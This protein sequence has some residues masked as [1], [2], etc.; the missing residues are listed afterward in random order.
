M[1]RR[2]LRIQLS[3]QDHAELKSLLRGGVQQVRVV[4]R[5]LA[6]LQMADGLTA[7]QVARSVCLTAK[8]VREIAHRY[9]SGGLEQALFEK[10][11]PGAAELLEPPQKQRIVAMV[12][13]SPP[14]GQARWTVRLITE[15]A[16]KRKLVPRVGRETIR[17]LLQSHDLKP[18]R[19]KNV[20]RGGTR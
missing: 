19:E 17:V 18:W 20:V 15:E 6:L 2:P 16:V 4:L 11:R 14:E 13:G 3:S 9:S 1:A 7:P 12:C 10:Q 5:A 8:A